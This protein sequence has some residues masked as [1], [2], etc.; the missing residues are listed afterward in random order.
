MLLP[1][2]S[3][4]EVE[5]LLVPAV[6]RGWCTQGYNNLAAMLCA[7][8]CCGLLWDVQVKRQRDVSKENLPI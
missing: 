6:R 3:G 5:V 4:C 7:V 1:P 8:C 2:G